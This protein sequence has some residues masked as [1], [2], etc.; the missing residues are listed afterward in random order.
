[1]KIIPV[2][3]DRIQTKHTNFIVDNRNEC[4]EKS[5]NKMIYEVCGWHQEDHTVVSGS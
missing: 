2:I 3:L 1:M 4:K 5:R